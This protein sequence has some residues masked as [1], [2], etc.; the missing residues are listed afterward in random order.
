VRSSFVSFAY[1]S[2]RAGRDLGAAF[3]P[4]EQA[5]RDALLQPIHSDNG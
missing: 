3:R 4:A 2:E 1:T 5:W